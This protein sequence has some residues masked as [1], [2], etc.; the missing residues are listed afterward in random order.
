MDCRSQVDIS[1]PLWYDYKHWGNRW[2][3][4]LFSFQ[5]HYG[6]IIRLSLWLRIKAFILF[7]FHYG[8]IIRFN[9][10]FDNRISVRFQFHYG[11]IISLF[12]Q[13]EKERVEIF[14]FHYGTIISRST[15]YVKIVDYQVKWKLNLEILQVK[16]VG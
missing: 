5:F 11:T 10:I 16:V 3:L 2:T 14:Q 15:T 8:T 7:Q 6:T 12:A 1:I 9:N 4:C 13:S